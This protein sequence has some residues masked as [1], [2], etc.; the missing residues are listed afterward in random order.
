MLLCG[1][2]CCLWTR[3]FSGAGLR[4]GRPAGKLSAPRASIGVLA[5]CPAR[6]CRHGHR[7]PRTP[8]PS[9]P[10]SPVP[11]PGPAVPPAPSAPVGPSR[12]MLLDAL[13]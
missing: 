10:I 4:R 7:S 5:H 2:G 1:A 9:L 6:P 3:G 12:L 11:R 13:P 8:Q